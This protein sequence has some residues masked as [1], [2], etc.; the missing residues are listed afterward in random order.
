MSHDN[1][2]SRVSERDM[3]QPLEALFRDLGTSRDGLTGIDAEKRL[4]E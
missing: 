2:K 3:N 4:K 1:K